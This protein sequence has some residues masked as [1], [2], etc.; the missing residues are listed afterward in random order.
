MLG[1]QLQVGL[2]GRPHLVG[3]EDFGQSVRCNRIAG[4]GGFDHSSIAIP[5]GLEIVTADV[6]LLQ[7]IGPKS[8]EKA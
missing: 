6:G 1:R 8:G 2:K 3:S 5:E 4:G 7:P